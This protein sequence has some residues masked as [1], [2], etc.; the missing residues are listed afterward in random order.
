MDL[1]SLPTTLSE[2]I[3]HFSHVQ[4][5]RNHVFLQ[6]YLDYEAKLRQI[7]A[8]EPGNL[9]LE[10]NYINTV[11]VFDGHEHTLKIRARNISSEPQT[12]R[13]CYLLPLSKEARRP[14]ASP[15][16]VPSRR[17]FQ[18]NF[19]IF[20]E[21]ALRYLDWTNVVAAGSSVVTSLLPV[22]ERYNKSRRDQRAYYN[23]KIAPASDVDLFIYGLDEQSALRKLEQIESNIRDAVLCDT[24]TVRTK[25]AVTIVTQYPIRHIQI[26]LR[27]YKSVS[28]ILTGFD[29]DCSCVAYDGSQVWAT[30]RAVV[31]FTTQ[32]NTIDLT[33]RSPSYE[34]RLSKYS[35]R[36]FEVYWPLLDRS[37]IDPTIFER[38]FGS[39]TGLARLLVLEALPRPDDRDAYREK[40]RKERG[41]PEL[42]YSA[43]RTEKLEGNVKDELPDE[44]P[45]W[46]DE[47]DVSNYHTITIPYG[48]KFRAKK[49]ER[50]LF[51]KDILLNAEWNRKDDRTVNLHRHPAFF[52]DMKDVFGDCCGSCPVPETDEEKKVAD[53][54]AKTYISGNIRFIVDD[55][56]RQEIGSFH[57]LSSDD[58]TEMAYLGDIQK[59]CQAIVDGDLDQ[60]QTWCQQ[61]STDINCRDH[62]GRTPLHL[63]AMCS[64]PEIVRCL[65]DNGARIIARTVD[66]LTAF[67]IAARRG[68][69]DIVQAMIDKSA[70]NAADEE[71]KN[72]AKDEEQKQEQERQDGKEERGSEKGSNEDDADD[73]NVEMVDADEGSDNDSHMSDAL[74]QGSFVKISENPGVS[75]TSSGDDNPQDPD[76][77]DP[78]VPAWDY[79]T[80]P[81]HL[82]IIEGYID[83]VR[84]II[85]QLD[86]DVSSPLVLQ[87]S[88]GPVHG[89]ILPIVLAARYSPNDVDMIKE[90]YDL[91]ALCTQAD[92]DGDTVLNHIVNDQNSNIVQLMYDLNPQDVKRAINHIRVALSYREPIDPLSISINTCNTEISLKLLDF[93]ASTQ[94]SFE[95][96]RMAYRRFHHMFQK[97]AGGAYMGIRSNRDLRLAWLTEHERPVI[98]AMLNDLPLVAQKLLHMGA[99]VN[100]LTSYANQPPDRYG[101]HI[102]N[103]KES[104]LDVVR[105]RIDELKEYLDDKLNGPSKL[106][107][108]L[109]N[110]ESYLGQYKAGSYQHFTASKSLSL[111][112]AVLNTMVNKREKKQSEFND[113]LKSGEPLFEEQKAIQSAL[114]I[115]RDIEKYLLEKG[116]KTYVELYPPPT[117]SKEAHSSLTGVNADDEE[118]EHSPYRTEFKFDG[119]TDGEG[120]VQKGYILLF[121]AAWEGN[122]DTLRVLTLSHW[123][124]D[125]SSNTV[126]RHSAAE[127]SLDVQSPLEVSV[128]DEAGFTPFSLSALR[129]NFDFARLV[130]EIAAVQYLPD[131]DDARYNYSIE[132]FGGYD[133]ASE[134]DSAGGDSDSDTDLR[135]ESRVQEK[136]VTFNVSE[137][138]ELPGTVGSKSPP[139]YLFN[140]G[141]EVYR[142]FDDIESARN[143]GVSVPD[144]WPYCKSFGTKEFGWDHFYQL[145]EYNSIF[146]DYPVKYAILQND[147][148]LFSFFLE[149]GEE[150]RAR[151]RERNNG[152]EFGISDQPMLF[153]DTA[154][155]CGQI[156]MMERIIQVTGPL[157]PLTRLARKYGTKDNSDEKPKYYRG[158]SVR[159][160]K[161]SDWMNNDRD[162]SE[163]DEVPHALEYIVSSRNLETVKWFMSGA[164]LES[165]MI[166]IESLKDNK[167]VQALQKHPLGVRG[168][169]ENW[170]MKFPNH[171]LHQVADDYKEDEA[172]PIL[173]HLLTVMPGAINS[174]DKSHGTP[175]HKAYGRCSVKLAKLLL[176]RGADPFKRGHDSKNVL[177][178][179][180]EC[181][182]SY[183]SFEQLLGLLDDSMT[184]ALLTQRSSV[185]SGTHTPFMTHLTE[186]RALGGREEL[187]IPLFLA[188]TKGRDLEMMDASGEYPLHYAIRN[189]QTSVA[190][191]IL[192][193]NPS[194][195]FLENAAGLTPLDLVN[196]TYLHQ[197]LE[198][199][200][201]SA[202]LKRVYNDDCIPIQTRMLTLSRRNDEYFIPD[203]VLRERKEKKG[204]IENTW[205]LCQKVAAANPSKRKLVSILDSAE[206]VKRLTAQSRE[207]NE[208]RLFPW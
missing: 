14:D 30:P 47:Q 123:T 69:V 98:N 3:P 50:L 158:L 52:G 73:D 148:E 180:L 83:V 162:D 128:Q 59:I 32:T 55:P 39:V 184:T 117:T 114:E 49:I 35:H 200:H 139:L 46:L 38:S 40:R 192:D 145:F 124:L 190:R 110:D 140:C 188:Y 199:G 86:V 147:Q 113:S 173:E 105:S 41:R 136:P 133:S 100:E 129:K 1:P 127:S 204:S 119:G 164:P 135:I 48:P 115:Y 120:I 163:S 84:L 4:G 51:A 160:K 56:G 134:S 79:R 185:Q 146:T 18:S 101:M 159:G 186:N 90:L 28:E 196:N 74:T 66:G 151:E 43:Y 53:E 202:A 182:P 142:L 181:C 24:T 130:L 108:R 194:L 68:N 187:L 189:N 70:K 203:N 99:N 75:Q 58:W 62:T 141:C 195:L 17:L 12:E 65:L 126:V 77:I 137:L 176:E 177:H 144:E 152:K 118:V 153:F 8:Q 170:I 71:E 150:W 156:D 106:T 122:L 172:Y 15:A 44:V 81:L 183:E 125:E 54:E 155:S 5:R 109:D 87:D 72:K 33:R 6:P 166:Y 10:N 97:Q 63:A 37:Q 198:P 165:Y 13:D 76:I 16:V 7:Y 78:N 132:L 107:C 111:A 22:G 27:L 121:E 94:I 138:E 20:T 19:D 2:F 161:R 154:A 45:D 80:T 206:I 91:G 96:Y 61:S 167:D 205:R 31:A 157:L 29:V 131:S 95:A 88:N 26:V 103:K 179:C 67:H 25:N 92:M 11:P 93:G 89:M 178:E 112:K 191:A 64:T 149:L 82:A 104:A 175:L 171:I 60:V 23:E 208:Q 42:G 207:L 9:L 169:I 116:A 174:V 201:R 143:A 168:I 102:Y 193:F 57:P 34:N 85:D 36:G 21:S 197:R